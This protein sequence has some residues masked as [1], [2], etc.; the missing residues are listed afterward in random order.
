M[1]PRTQA[2]LDKLNEVQ[3]FRNIGVCDTS[4]AEILKS[5]AEA[6]ESCRSSE[7]KELRAEAANQYRERLAECCPERLNKWNEIVRAIKPSV[8]AVVAEKTRVVVEENNLP[9]DFVNA[10]RWDILH[11]CMEAEYFDVYPPAFF[12]SQ[13]FWYVQGHFPCGWKGKCPEG[14]L[15]IY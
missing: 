11:L 5:W 8:E 10:V 9:Q 3:W 12:T 6:M 15:V 4:A 14:M 2:T 13:A 1:H 7:W